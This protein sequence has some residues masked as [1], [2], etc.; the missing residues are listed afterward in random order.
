MSPD[1]IAVALTTAVGAPLLDPL[2]LDAPDAAGA[3]AVDDSS[4]DELPQATATSMAKAS[5]A[6]T[7]IGRLEKWDFFMSFVLLGRVS[8]S[9][10]PT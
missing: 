4:S 1:G 5:N 7:T 9:I 10:D 2:L 6:N 3:D 8:D